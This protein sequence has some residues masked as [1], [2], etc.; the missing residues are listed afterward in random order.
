MPTLGYQT[1]ASANVDSLTCCFACY[2]SQ[3]VLFFIVF[4]KDIFYFSKAYFG[5]RRKDDTAIIT[6]AFKDTH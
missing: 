4:F 2:L 5:L 1:S 6:P 3:E